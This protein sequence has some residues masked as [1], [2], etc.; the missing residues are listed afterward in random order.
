M[1]T[2]HD[3][4]RPL[5]PARNVFRTKGGRL[6]PYALAC[7][8]VEQYNTETTRVTLWSEHGSLHVR[9]HDFA[10]GKRIFWDCPDTLTDA[11]KRFD[12]YK[13]TRA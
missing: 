3:K 11:R 1:E 4:A 9:V 10:E 7:G 12:R 2:P 8:Y 5:L 13:K 6:T